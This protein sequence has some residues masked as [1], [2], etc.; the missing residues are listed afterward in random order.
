MGFLLFPLTTYILYHKSAHLSSVFVKKVKKILH[1]KAGRKS[2]GFVQ[3]AQ[4][5]SRQA[6]ASRRG[7]EGVAALSVYL[8]DIP[9]LFL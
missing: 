1:K 7:K 3:N 5:G 4:N 6:L 9:S 2:C 8:T